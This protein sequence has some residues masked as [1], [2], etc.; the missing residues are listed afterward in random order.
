MRSSNR[1]AVLTRAL[2]VM[3]TLAMVFSAMP[4]SAVA[5]TFATASGQGSGEQEVSE[6]G[7]G[8]QKVDE[9]ENDEQ[10]ASEQG[11]GEQE[12]DE[13]ENDEQEAS[14]QEGAVKLIA[15]PGASAAVAGLVYNGH[16]QT[17]V[18]LGEGYQVANGTATDASD[19]T[20]T[21]T[22][23]VGYA[24]EDGTTDAV[25]ISWSIAK[26]TLT[27]TYAGET[28]TE[29]STPAYAV[30][31]TG[32]VG[33]ETLASLAQTDATFHMPAVEQQNDDD[34]KAGFSKELVPEGGEAKNYAFAYVGGTLTVKAAETTDSLAPGTYTLTANLAMPGQYNPVISGL[35]VYAN[36]P[37]N[38]FG[39]TIDE[40]D[41]AEVHDTVPSTPQS[42]NARLV[43][44]ADGTHTLI[45][46]I[47]NPIFTTQQIGT[48][49][50]LANVRTERVTPTDGGG[51]F[52]GTYNQRADR[53]HMLAVDLPTADV[54]GTYTYDFKG[55][56]LY[57]VP[58]NLELAPSGD[59]ALELKVEMGTLQKTSDSTELPAFAQTKKD[60]PAPTPQPD[61]PDTPTPTPAPDPNKGDNNGNTNN[62]S[63][64]NGGQNNNGGGAN[65]TGGTT[66]RGTG[67]GDNI[68]TEN[69]HLA[70]G[71]YTVSAN[72]WVNKAEAGLPLS[73]H[74]T[75]S[76]FP[77]SYSVTRNATLRVES[78]GHAYVTI[79]IIIQSRVMHV[80]S[81]SGLN[82]V[83]SSRD[84]EGGLSSITVDLGVLRDT[85]TITKQ[86]RAS[87]S[88]GTLAHTIIGG[89]TNRNWGVTFEVAF[90][91]NVTQTGGTLPA[92][93]RKIIE[94]QGSDGRDASGEAKAADA[95]G[96]ALAA[97]DETS[98]ADA[99]EGDSTEAADVTSADQ[100]AAAALLGKGRRDATNGD[101]A[102]SG[103]ATSG[104]WVAGLVAAF[105]V[106]AIVV[107]YAVRRRKTAK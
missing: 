9:Q 37:D 83:S 23:A 97:L 93:A 14:G 101:D 54:N 66:A 73:P 36:S 46:P 44:Q 98:S 81:L 74:F 17:G 57:A 68:Q 15:K 40:N 92:A 20:A 21:V 72:I 100:A 43:V 60:D 6:Q 56:K 45:L 32:F 103:S 31:V 35:T 50:G 76:A 106:A 48:C 39:P 55:S 16:E 77:P 25:Q 67:A 53:I 58:L 61:N 79:P 71:T 90:G 89:E 84:G 19:Y 91:N 1:Y 18:S 94:A 87:I 41:P 51:T 13:Q 33:G 82:I 52:S 34:L 62:N 70:A 7:S 10:E 42:M 49:L 3:L 12:A 24:W 105:V 69:G 29:G 22:P 5:E 104:S 96:A 27:A 11:S 95:A 107:A 99:E 85:S 8:D 88:L 102:S 86:A 65:D 63:S 2:A 64:N 47:K 59:I 38:P 30:D 4:L 75:N 26:A 28:V 80:N 78:D